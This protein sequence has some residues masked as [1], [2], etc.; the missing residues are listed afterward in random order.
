LTSVALLTAYLLAQRK[1][2]GHSY[3]PTCLEQG[4]CVKRAIV[5]LRAGLGRNS[6]IA[7]GVRQTRNVTYEKPDPAKIFFAR[8]PLEIER[9]ARIPRDTRAS[10]AHA[11]R[12]M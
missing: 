5:K 7:R 2:R 10:N 11:L 4:I 6:R 8:F 1:K 3:F 12:E 9:F